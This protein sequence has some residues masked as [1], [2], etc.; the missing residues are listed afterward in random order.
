MQK[1]ALNMPE[2]FSCDHRAILFFGALRSQVHPDAWLGWVGKDIS[3]L[4]ALQE[5]WKTMS[6]HHDLAQAFSFK[7]LSSFF[8]VCCSVDST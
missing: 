2:S 5:L 6:G 3:A 1:Q 4:T 7:A 8:S